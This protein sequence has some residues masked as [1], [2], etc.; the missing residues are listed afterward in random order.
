VRGTS[1][2]QKLARVPPGIWE[3]ELIMLLIFARVT[4]AT[5]K[6]ATRVA[7]DTVRAE[8]LSL[9]SAESSAQDFQEVITSRTPTLGRSC[10]WRAARANLCATSCTCIPLFS[11]PPRAQ[12]LLRKTECGLCLPL[13]CLR[14]YS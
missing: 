11:A 10:F 5:V 8:W 4:T 7:L 3:R 1:M 14:S 6:P 12:S 2:W 13:F 9:M